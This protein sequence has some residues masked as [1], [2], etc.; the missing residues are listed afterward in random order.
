[1]VRK[2]PYLIDLPHGPGTARKFVRQV[3]VRK[4]S[5]HLLS[6]PHSNLQAVTRIVNK[7]R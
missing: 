7:H 5:P 6:L 3:F 2:P 4:T 1:M